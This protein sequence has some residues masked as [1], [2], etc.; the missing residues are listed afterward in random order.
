MSRQFLVSRS[1]RK[2]SMEIQENLILKKKREILEKQKTA[3]LVKVVT[4]KMT[5]TSSRYEKS[6]KFLILYNQYFIHF[7]PLKKITMVVDM[8]FFCMKKIFWYG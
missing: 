7:F 4:S 2:I 5:S 6:L 1:D 8:F 3:E